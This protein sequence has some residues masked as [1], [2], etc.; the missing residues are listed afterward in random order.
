MKK[1][2]K[3]TVII[4]GLLLVVLVSLPFLFKGK[5]VSLIKEEANKN[6]NAKMDFKDAG[7]S[8]IRSFPDFSLTL[9]DLSIINLAPFEN[10]TLIYAKELGVTVDIMSVI[11][12]SEMNIKSV[13]IDGAVMKFQV[14]KE[15]KASWDIAKPSEP[16]APEGAPSKFK[17]SLKS[18]AITNSRILYDDQS[19]GFYLLM[20]DV[21]HTGKGDFTQDLFTLSTRT[22][23][24]ASTM[25][26]EGLTYIASAKTLLTADLEMDMKNMKFTFKDNKAQLNDLQMLVDGFVAMP[27]TNIDMDLK[28]STPQT[29]FKTMLSM[30]PAVYAKD[31]GSL[32]ASG[33][34]TLSG[35]LKGRYN[36]VSM[37]SFGMILA[38]DN[39]RFKYPSL[40]AEVKDVFVDLKI[41]NPDGVVDHTVVNLSRLHANLAGDVFDAKLLVR[42]PVSDPDLDASL[43]GRIVLDNIGKF[44]PLDAGTTLTGTLVSDVTVKGR[45][46]AIQGQK[47]DQFTAAGQLTITGMNYASP[48]VPKPVAINNLQLSVT[49]KLL[50]M[51]ALDMKVGNTDLQANGSLENALGYYLKN[52]LLKGTLTLTSSQVDLNEWM[53]SAPSTDTAAADTA[54]MSVFLVPANIDFRLNSSIGKLKYTDMTIDNVKGTLIVKDQTIRM[55]GVNMN[56][57]KGSMTMNGG[58]STKSPESPDIDFDLVIK[59]FDIQQTAKT[60]ITVEKLAPLAKYC[61]GSFG[62]SM[63]VTGKLDKQMSP[64]INTLSGSGKLNTS[65]VVISNFEA[66]NKVADVLKMES[67]KKIEVPN[68]NPS[69]KFVNGRVYVDPFDVSLNGMKSR[70]AG[71]NGFDQTIDYTMNTDIPRSMLGGSANAVIDNLVSQ[72]NAKGANFSVG[73]TIPVAIGMKGTVTSPKITTDL[74]QQGAKA[75]ESLKAAAAAEFEK[76]KAAA[77][78]KAREELE[79]Q[80]AAAEAKAREELE[81]QKARA[82]AEAD[83]LKKEAEAKAKSAT[84]SLK[85]AAEREAKKALEQI[86]PFKKK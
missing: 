57:M 30:I 51:P 37:P 3:W 33:K 58:Y 68:M 46:S 82:Q 44:V 20:K 36:A 2:I 8:L 53:S 86:N 74:N 15:G 35:Y 27:D 67:W 22:E 78:A 47:Y 65:K 72:A 42:T 45:L 13:T 25:S 63:N 60:F 66:F 50:L 1:F 34:M 21:N 31:F 80:K 62:T 70:I 43:K 64:V 23:A 56:L 38:I 48:S 16:A 76:Q 75:L 4:F 84:D 52:E 69:F 40:P 61:T 85:K 28:F 73:E 77:E 19:L 39:G 81:K 32:Q 17:G 5:I 41:D 18:Y 54:P 71:S 79:K 59:D 9:D 7:L 11:R 24:S 26:Y 12:G 14:T 83:R 49:P 6:L 29:D 10:D 55:E